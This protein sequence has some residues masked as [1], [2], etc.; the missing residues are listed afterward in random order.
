MAIPFSSTYEGCAQMEYPFVYVYRL[1]ITSFSTYCFTGRGK[2]LH[3]DVLT[4]GVVEYC[5]SKNA[6]SDL[7]PLLLL[8]L[9]PFHNPF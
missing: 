7:K 1:C 5:E 3:L 2:W 9:L 6:T 8:L 4:V